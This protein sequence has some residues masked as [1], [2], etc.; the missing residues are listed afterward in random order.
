M[1]ELLKKGIFFIIVIA[2]VL[3]LL[4][5]P[6]DSSENGELQEMDPIELASNESDNPTEAI[7]EMVTVDI[8][9]EVKTPG[10]YELKRNA[11]VNDAVALAGGF[12]PDADQT[13]VNLAQKVQDEM[14]IIVPNITDQPSQSIESTSSGGS[15]KV[16]LN[17]AT[18]EE[19]EGLA[20][21]G[22]TKAKAIIQYREENGY[23]QSADELL[24][25]TGIGE[26]TLETIREMIQL[27]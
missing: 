5:L 15:D 21:I 25:V 26:K 20:G 24:N 27:P 8:K 17:A 6:P 23:F 3:L 4:W 9:G 12:T 22:P 2:V 14:L 7:E 16:N 13:V 1:N 19:I 18:Q 11:R 10:V